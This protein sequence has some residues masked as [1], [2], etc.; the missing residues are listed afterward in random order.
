MEM[1]ILFLITGLIV[2]FIIAFLFFKNKNANIDKEKSNL[3]VELNFL[4]SE[5]EKTENSLIS[6]RK[7]SEEL[8]ARVAKAEE[9][10]KN[11]E[12]KLK[13]QKQE[14][15]DMQKKLV[16][17]FENLANKILKENSREF[18]EK[19]QKNIGDILN[20]LKEKIE[21]FEKKVEETYDKEVRDKISLREEVKKLYELNTKISQEANN[22]TK[23]LKGDSKK[24]GNW[25]EVILEKVLERSGLR[26][27]IEYDIQKRSPGD[28]GEIL[29]PDIIVNL[30]DNKHVI[31]DSKVS[32]IAYENY[33]NSEIPEEKE[34]F[35]KQHLDSLKNHVKGLSEKKYQN[36]EGVNSPDFVLMFLP[37]ES[38]FS[39]AIQ[40][41]N[42]LF[43]FAWDRKIVIVSP[44]TLLATLRTIASIWKQ[45]NQTKNALDIAKQSGALYDKFVGL[46]EDI[47]SIGNFI[48]KS[49]EAYNEAVKKISTGRGNLIG[50]VEA[51]QELGAKATKSI[52]DKFLNNEDENITVSED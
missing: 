27:Q 11:Q 20:P 42:E 12:E 23:A 38:S 1:E 21:K 41:E 13:A 7:K 8:S 30:P 34:K 47:K 35:L 3:E 5:K 2:G 33:V 31:I 52:P 43:N 18:T 44:T 46:L 6:E 9:I 14:I 28:E 45:E 51:L 50:K 29:I 39:I 48:S 22:L 19:N 24:Q 40:A 25:G 49:N 16:A 26:K 32:L 15:E 4:K 17:E 36:V 10:F 37:I